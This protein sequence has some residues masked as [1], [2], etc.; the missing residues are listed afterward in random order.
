MSNELIVIEEK[1]ALTVF[2]QDNGL[3]GII[4]QVEISLGYLLVVTT[5]NHYKCMVR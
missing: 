4:K 2:T 5:S 3:D 1:N